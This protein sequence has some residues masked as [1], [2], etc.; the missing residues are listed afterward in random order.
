MWGW[1]KAEQVPYWGIL[2][3]FSYFNVPLCMTFLLSSCDNHTRRGDATRRDWV[4]FRTRTVTHCQRY[5][6]VRSGLKRVNMGK[7]HQKH[8]CYIEFHGEE[9]ERICVWTRD[10]EWNSAVW[11]GGAGS[12]QKRKRIWG[13]FQWHPC[14]CNILKGHSE[15]SWILDTGYSSGLPPW[16]TGWA[17]PHNVINLHPGIHVCSGDWISEHFSAFLTCF[18]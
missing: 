17:S 3:S 5:E 14:C 10:L 1:S 16:L 4:V 15:K 11:L 6:S 12:E 18:S 8:S 2:N 13:F 9:T 7:A